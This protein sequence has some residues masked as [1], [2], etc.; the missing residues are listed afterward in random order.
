[1]LSATELAIH[2][3]NTE[4]FIQ[5][6]P[7]TIVLIPKV[8]VTHNGTSEFFDDDRRN[9]QDFKVIWAGDNGIVRPVGQDGGVRRFDFILVGRHDAEVEINDTWE[10]GDQLFIVEY[11]FPSLGYEVKVGGVSHGSKPT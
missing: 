10:L 6:D 9:A 11:K 3:K 7:T 2:R 1:M 5:A 4:R 8:R